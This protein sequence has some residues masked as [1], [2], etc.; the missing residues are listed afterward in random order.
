MA[1][2]QIL[3]SD[4]PVDTLKERL[5]S[6]Y[7]RLDTLKFEE[8]N[9]KYDKWADEMK[10]ELRS[11]FINN[12]KTVYLGRFYQGNFELKSPKFN[13]WNY[14]LVSVRYGKGY[15]KICLK[16]EFFKTIAVSTLLLILT[17]TLISLF[18]PKSGLLPLFVGLTVA[19]LVL[20]KVSKTV[21]Y[22]RKYTY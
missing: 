3:I 1:A 17:S 2:E 21:K 15:S 7:E 18:D 12:P 19:S 14:V 22:F 4:L 11:Q 6:S 10:K 5:F 16:L 20:L 8:F 13:Y 9:P